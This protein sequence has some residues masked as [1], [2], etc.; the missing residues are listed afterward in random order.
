MAFVHKSVLFTQAVDAL[1]VRPGGV[2]MD[3]TAGGGGHSAAILQ[4]LGG[5]GTLLCVDQDPDAV[6]TLGKRFAGQEQVR[7]VQEN[8]SRTPEILDRLGIPAVDGA[9]MDLGVSSYQLDTAERGFSFHQNAALDMRMSQSG[10]SARDVVNTYSEQALKKILY[11]YGE[12][13][14]AGKI[15]REIVRARQEKPVETTFELIEIIK[16]AMPAAAQRESHPARRTFQAIRIEV[17]DELGVLSSTL[18]SV[19][20][21]LAPGGRLAVITFHSLEDRMVKRR[22]AQF[23]TGCTCPKDFPICVCGNTPRGRLPFKLQAPAQ[24]E[25]TENPRARSAKLR[26]VEKL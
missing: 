17:N 14:F 8:F 16:R 7:L 4:R 3:L 10:T 5:Q 21:R 19:F 1:A 11:E 20:D 2:Y 6:A 13:R 23:C 15:A 9:L 18:D 22:F 26:C 25:L 24:E 12:E